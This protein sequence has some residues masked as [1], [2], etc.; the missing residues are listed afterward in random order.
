M[1]AVAALTVIA[2]ALTAP[3]AASAEGLPK[4]SARA[5]VWLGRSLQV[6]LR[7]PQLSVPPH[8]RLDSGIEEQKVTIALP[9]ETPLDQVLANLADLLQCHWVTKTGPPDQLILKRHPEVAKLLRARAQAHAELEQRV[10][11]EQ[12][13]LMLQA[14]RQARRAVDQPPEE[15]FPGHFARR[16]VPPGTEPLIPFLDGL[17]SA[18]WDR[19]CAETEL[20]IAEAA[21]ARSAY[22]PIL[23]WQ[24]QRLTPAQQQSIRAY[25]RDRDG[26]DYSK[27]VVSLANRGGARLM[28]GIFAGDW[29]E[30]PLVISIEGA[31]LHRLRAGDREPVFLDDGPDFT[32]SIP[33]ALAGRA[34]QR[35]QLKDAELDYAQACAALADTL[36]VP[37]LADYYTVSARVQRSGGIQ[38][39][40][41][42]FRVLQAEFGCSFAWHRGMLLVRRGDWPLVDER[43]ISEAILEKCLAEKRR[44]RGWATLNAATLAW[45]AARIRPVQIDCVRSLSS[46]EDRNIQ[47][48]SEVDILRRE[49]DLLRLIGSLDSGR[50]A[51]LL[52]GGVPWG[53]LYRAAPAPY[54][55]CIRYRAPWLLNSAE[56]QEGLM[57]LTPAP[58]GATILGTPDGARP[59]RIEFTYRDGR[60]L[61]RHFQDTMVPSPDGA[62]N[63]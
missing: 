53:D 45:L 48:A 27:V 17:G 13:G 20:D 12:K 2:L 32:N 40:K 34:R 49:Y 46:H 18:D 26:I 63:R 47:F 4:G 58:E 62:G 60:T 41:D 7:D 61:K 39:V 35:V 8:L 44:G 28:M 5:N 14:F 3:Y 43:E 33:E 52:R 37:V 50:Q 1:R 24:F 54:V 31:A 36:K 16:G 21:G 15:I 25:L 19:L 55:Q 11:A 23:T 10:R 59:L 42:L 29:L 22:N 6:V 51:R 57:R 38:A 9:H 30:A 56:I